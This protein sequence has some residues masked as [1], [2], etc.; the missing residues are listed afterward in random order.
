M[1]KRGIT[2][3]VSVILILSLLL[4]TG[5]GSIKDMLPDILPG[6]APAEESAEDMTVVDSYTVEDGRG[7]QYV[8]IPEGTYL[9]DTD[10][11]TQRAL[12]LLQEA[13][14][15]REKSV[16]IKDAGLWYG[17]PYFYAMPY[18]SFWV[19]DVSGTGLYGSEMFDTDRRRYHF[20]EFTYYD[21]TDEELEEMKTQIDTVT[22]E[23][24]AMVPEDADDWTKARIVHDELCR[25]V[26]YDKSTE[27]P[28]CHDSYG[29][30]VN[31]LAVCS[32][33]SC[34]FSHIMSQLG[35]YCPLSYSDDHAW[36]HVSVPSN[37]QYI[38][39]TWDDPDLTDAYGD[40]Y[41]F[42]DYFFLT[43]EEVES[44]DSHSIESFDPYVQI[45]NPQE[46]N[47]YTHEGYELDSYDLDEIINVFYRQYESGAN[48]LTIRFENEEDYQRALLWQDS[49]SEDLYAILSSMDYFEM[50]YIWHNDQMKTISF[51]LYAA[52]GAEE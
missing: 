52:E 18:S 37:Q 9:I 15:R 14:G 6:A 30:L 31:G 23:I 3:T 7:N 39:T 19:K 16:C 10:G 51:G 2:I 50:Y 22:D 46:Y 8:I 42:Y 25:R 29:A 17:M 20:Y 44:I 1:K 33:Y 38:D 13:V 48:L 41:V 24:I 35:F 28:H 27:A 4:Q 36:N 32:G 12:D 5:C 26:T 45:D 49:E 47:Y 34:A 43:R 11:D 40:P 21:L